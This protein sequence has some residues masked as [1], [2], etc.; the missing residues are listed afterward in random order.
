MGLRSVVIRK[1]TPGD[2]TGILQCLRIAFEPYRASYPPEAYLDTV[3]TELAL[4]HRLA[5]MSVFVAVSDAGEIVGS[6][7]CHRVD[8]AVHATT[9]A[10]VHANEGH[11]RGMAVLPDWQGSGIA[12]QLLDAAESELRAEGCSLI[13]LDTTEP[14]AKAIHFY[15]RNGYRS[16]GNDTYYCGMRRLQFIKPIAL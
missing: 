5:T 12:Q 16:S 9:H 8:P 3:I 1:A 10:V 2:S 4:Q 11:L 13:S 7:A 6:I 14:L 15:E